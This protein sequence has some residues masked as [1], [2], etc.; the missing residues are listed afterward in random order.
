MSC[1]TCNNN[2]LTKDEALT[3]CRKCI[4]VDIIHV[5][6]NKLLQCT[7]S[8]KR[9]CLTIWQNGNGCPSGLWNILNKPLKNNK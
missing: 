6:S 4:L 9:L 7:K 1:H 8:P 3:L 2:T 5:N